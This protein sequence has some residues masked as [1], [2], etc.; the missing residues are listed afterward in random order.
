MKVVRPLSSVRY[1]VYLN[2]SSFFWLNQF[3]NVAI[4]GCLFHEDWDKL[5][6]D[7]EGSS[8]VVIA[9]VDCTAGGKSKCEEAH[10]ASLFGDDLGNCQTFRGF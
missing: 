8:T 7:F 3:R 9:D 5:T 10:F 4:Y 6:K 1:T 2:F